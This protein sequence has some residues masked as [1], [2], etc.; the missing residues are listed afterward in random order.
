MTA[1]ERSCRAGHMPRL[2][3]NR[4]CVY[5]DDTYNDDNRYYE[6]APVKIWMH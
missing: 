1:E 3:V 4:H 2:L 6:D 5:R